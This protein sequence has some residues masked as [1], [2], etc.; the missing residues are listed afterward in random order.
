MGR[1]E[2]LTVTVSALTSGPLSQTIPRRTRAVAN[3]PIIL[4][5]VQIRGTNLGEPPTGVLPP[6]V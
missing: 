1:L 4:P 6:D 5:N 3:V 2:L